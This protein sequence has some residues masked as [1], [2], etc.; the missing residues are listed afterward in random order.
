M[1]TEATSGGRIRYK[2]SEHMNKKKS[3]PHGSNFRGELAGR[4][5][6]ERAL[7]FKKKRP[8]GVGEGRGGRSRKGMG[9][10]K[11]LYRTKAVT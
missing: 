9:T 1:Q 10:A 8:R 7:L 3:F 5:K 11:N 2:D 4:K 6:K